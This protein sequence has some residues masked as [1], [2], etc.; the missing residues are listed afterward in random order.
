MQTQSAHISVILSRREFFPGRGCW[1]GRKIMAVITGVICARDRGKRSGEVMESTE[2]EGVS[3]VCL[4]LC[5]REDCR[6]RGRAS[7]WNGRAGA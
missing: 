7:C 5:R 4:C 6:E 2:K 1:C 3:C